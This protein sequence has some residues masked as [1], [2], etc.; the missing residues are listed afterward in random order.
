MKKIISGLEDLQAYFDK[1]TGTYRIREDRVEIRLPTGA[2]W[3]IHEIE[4]TDLVVRGSQGLKPVP[5]QITHVQAGNFAC[6]GAVEVYTARAENLYVEYSIKAVHSINV[7]NNI[8]VDSG[9]KLLAS[10]VVR[11]ANSIIMTEGTLEVPGKGALYVMNDIVTDGKR[12]FN[13]RFNDDV[14]SLFMENDIQ[15]KARDPSHIG[16][17]CRS[18]RQAIGKNS[19]MIQLNGIGYFLVKKPLEETI[20]VIEGT[21]KKITV[22]PGG[23]MILGGGLENN[24][25]GKISMRIGS[26]KSSSNEKR[27][28]IFAVGMNETM[29]KTVEHS[30][31]ANDAD[32]RKMKPPNRNLIAFQAAMRSVGVNP[33][34]MARA[35]I[36]Q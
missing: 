30:K 27:L 28:P 9:G 6:I 22:K 15:L 11:V 34:A 12:R 20:S 4:A 26:E 36:A 16:S 25:Y 8:Y 14:G 29:A 10:G 18:L 13:I 24:A 17:I 33:L 32:L 1:S 2:A 5:L 19:E 23:S 35:R 3:H 21:V 7:L 31:I